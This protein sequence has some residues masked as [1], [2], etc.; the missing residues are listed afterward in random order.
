MKQNNK[1]IGRMAFSLDTI[2]SSDNQLVIMDGDTLFI[3][4]TPNEVTVIGEVNQ[5]VSHIFNLDYGVDEEYIKEHGD[6]DLHKVIKYL[7]KMVDEKKLLRMDVYYV[8]NCNSR[9]GMRDY[10]IK[11]NYAIV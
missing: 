10:E 4:D 6:D 8:R 7:N 11:E 1:P 3:P 2:L 9:Q 5:P